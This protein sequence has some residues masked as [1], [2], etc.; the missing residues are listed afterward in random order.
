MYRYS[1]RKVV[2]LPFTDEQIWEAFLT[3]EKLW[4]EALMEGKE[5][6][7]ALMIATTVLQLQL[8][9]IGDRHPGAKR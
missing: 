5:E 3:I 9:P 7:M 6:H 4:G 2:E 1:V 8:P